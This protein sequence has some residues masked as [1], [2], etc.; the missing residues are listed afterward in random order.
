[1]WS[2]SFFSLLIFTGLIISVFYFGKRTFGYSHIRHTISELGQMDAPHKLKVNYGVFLPTAVG[3]IAIALITWITEN[4][5]T[6]YA[7][8]AGSVGTGYLIAAFFPA[9]P[10]SP[11][12]GSMRQQIHNA[13]G[14]V[15]Y[16]GGA[17]SLIIL[18][19]NSLLL[20]PFYLTSAYI[21]LIAAA[22]ISLPFLKSIRGFIQR[23]AE[24]V[25]FGNLILT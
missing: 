17:A 14:A 5:F 6:P 24:L 4:R 19:K 8:L 20:E 1:M 25:L 23:I 22:G 21:L 2:S 7:L 9:D 15:Q 11:I 13:G 18:S 16:L 10:G 3:L 12:W